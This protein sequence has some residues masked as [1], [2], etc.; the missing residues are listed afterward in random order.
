MNRTLLITKE[1]IIAYKCLVRNVSFNYV[2]HDLIYVSV[3]NCYVD[4]NLIT[5]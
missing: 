5:Q 1:N 3:Y 2:I 4:C